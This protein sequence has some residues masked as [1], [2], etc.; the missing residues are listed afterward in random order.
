MQKKSAFRQESLDRIASPEQLNDYIR[1]SGPSIWLLLGAL[2][3]IVACLAIWGFTGTLPVTYSLNGL[4]GDKEVVCF[5]PTG[6]LD[7]DILGSKAQI[8]LPNGTTIGGTVKE[9]AA[10]PSSAEELAASLGKAWF[11]SHLITGDYSYQVIISV[12]SALPADTLVRVALVIDEI[13]PIRYI[14]S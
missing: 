3:V 4:A 12:E 5:L 9:V 13:K 7:K 6:S 10:I 2:M 8:T 1:V 14:L 11:I